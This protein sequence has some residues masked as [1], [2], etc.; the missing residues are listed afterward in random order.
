MGIQS[1][2]VT[3]KQARATVIADVRAGNHAADAI[4][5]ELSSK[6]DVIIMDAAQKGMTMISASIEIDPSLLTND[7]DGS[8]GYAAAAT[9]RQDLY[10]ADFHPTMYQFEPPSMLYFDIVWGD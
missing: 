2:A 6:M 7:P 1:T 5:Q 10:E 4:Y 9:L 8:L 3:A